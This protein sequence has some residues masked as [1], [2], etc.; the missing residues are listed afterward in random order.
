MILFQLRI[1]RSI[2]DSSKTIK[3]AK[4]KLTE[5]KTKQTISKKSKAKQTEKPK[6]KK[7][8]RKRK[9]KED[10][11]KAAKPKRP[12]KRRKTDK[13]EEL[14]A[15]SKQD[16]DVARPGVSGSINQSA[17]IAGTSAQQ[18][19]TVS[20]QPQQPALNVQWTR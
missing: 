3:K 12:Y 7:R 1:P 14:Q 13:A 18:P 8:G 10:D 2:F 17:A 4:Q 6:G 5:K 19:S 9:V 15:A 20:Q 16:I 11:D